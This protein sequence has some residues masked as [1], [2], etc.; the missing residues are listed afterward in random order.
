MQGR[1]TD[2]HERTKKLEAFIGDSE[3]DRELLEGM[4]MDRLTHELETDQRQIMH[5][6]TRMQAIDG[7]PHHSSGADP[8]RPSKDN[9]VDCLETK[10]RGLKR[11]IDWLE[12][13][14]VEVPGEAGPSFFGDRDDVRSFGGIGAI[15]ADGLRMIREVARAPQ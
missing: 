1:D 13:P 3:L 5:L 7:E 8:Q 14:E 15:T 9:R 11:R 10:Y 6:Q 12:A 2:L 4:T